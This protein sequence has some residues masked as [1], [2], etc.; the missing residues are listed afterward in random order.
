MAVSKIAHSEHFRG[1]IRED[2]INNEMRSE[3]ALTMSLLGLISEEQRIKSSK[4]QAFWIGSGDGDGVEAS[5][6][7]V[8][9][10]EKEA[11]LKAMT[12]NNCN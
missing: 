4:V 1:N 12:K 9:R 3:A 5:E 2:V 8:I 6:L 7:A 10:G 11:I